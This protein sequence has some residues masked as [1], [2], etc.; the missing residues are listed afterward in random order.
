MR[1]VGDNILVKVVSLVMEVVVMAV[2]LPVVEVAERN[3]HM[4]CTFHRYRLL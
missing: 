2:D 1:E 3:H 4:V